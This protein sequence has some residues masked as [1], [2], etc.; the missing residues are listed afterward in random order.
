MPGH[1]I[2]AIVRAKNFYVEGEKLEELIQLFN[3]AN[4]FE[5]P[6]LGKSYL[7]PV[8]DDLKPT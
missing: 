2:N 3:E 7:V 8:D 4:D 5:V 6:K 1:T